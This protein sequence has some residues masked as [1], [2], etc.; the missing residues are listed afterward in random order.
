MTGRHPPSPRVI[1]PSP[2]CA[3]SNLQP[4]GVL[5]LHELG[6]QEA[7]EATAIQTRSLNYYTK[8]GKLIYSDPRG[9]HAGYKVPQCATLSPAPVPLPPAP[10]HPTAAPTRAGTRSTAASSR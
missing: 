2:A 4:S 7:L 10:P 5:A 8:E 1:S 6:L 3:R 9:I